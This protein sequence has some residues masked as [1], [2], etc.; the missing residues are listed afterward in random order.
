MSRGYQ[1]CPKIH[2][3]RVDFQDQALYARKNVQ[4]WKKGC[5]FGHIDKFK[6][7]T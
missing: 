6:E 5:V 4:K 1:A 7:R 3:I 2:I